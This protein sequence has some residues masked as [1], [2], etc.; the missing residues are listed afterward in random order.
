MATLLPE[1]KQ[2]FETS[3]GAPLVGGK[4][5]TY[6]AGTN[7]PRQTF[8][9]AAG[10]TP[11]TN[12][13][14][15]DA[16]GE[17]T[18]FWAGSYKVILKDSADVT[19]WTVDGLGGISLA[20][21]A[22]TS[23]AGLVGFL[24]G[25]VYAA[26]SIGKWLQDLALSAGASF[27]GW[28][29]SGAGAVLRT[30]LDKLRDQVSVFDFMTA[31]Q[32]A[33][34]RG[35]AGSLDVTAAVQAAID[36]LKYGGT[37]FFPPGVY[38]LTSVVS[39]YAGIT[40]R[41]SSNV[42]KTTGVRLGSEK[43]TYIFQATAATHLF[44]ILSSV[45][46]ET[47]SHIR[48]MDMSL[49]AIQ[50]PIYKDQP[51]LGKY[52]IHCS[53]T[54]P[55]SGYHLLIER[56]SFYNFE[57]AISAVGY[58]TGAGVDWQFDN[59]LVQTCNFYQNLRS[60]YLDTLNA[61][62][63]HISKCTFNLPP[64]AYG[65]HLNR[66]GYVLISGSYAVPG[67]DGAGAVATGTE[68]VR[69]GSWPDHLKM[70]QCAGSDTLAYFI[71]VDTSTGF[72]NVYSVIDLDGCVCEAPLLFERQCHVVSRNSRYLF[73]PTCTGADIFVESYSDTFFPATLK[74]TMS[75]L[76]PRLFVSPGSTQ[77]SGAVAGIATAVA[78][79]LFALPVSAGMYVVYVYIV[80]AGVL[81]MSTARIGHD[82]TVL[83]RMGGDNAANMTITVAG[84]N[85]QCTQIS[86]LPQT[87]NY[88]YYR[89][90]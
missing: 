87:V 53:G 52:G 17:A 51:V 90:A 67:Y 68:F 36:S 3:T 70:V 1:G 2:S 42:D 5:Y 43:P 59:V 88:A 50:A 22:S 58:D 57:R 18:V 46:V 21:L 41:G 79:T 19:I 45:G 76:R 47:P 82:G 81:Y 34:V 28:I 13:V 71:R 48:V 73:N 54:R 38:K 83:T 85:V 24:Y 15:L 74:W 40:L 62:A 31:A 86:G 77:T 61:D 60:V 33:D 26:G 29:Q 7:T 56:C 49:S 35:Q 44:Q 84:A 64:A 10:T 55:Y 37:L 66:A 23:G 32:I 39:L 6:D 11:N 80:G 69:Y 63:W 9:D 16:R 27:I 72:E 4:L 30:I 25:A 78:T 89:V 65:V 14:I 20:D 12:P 75:G 8:Q